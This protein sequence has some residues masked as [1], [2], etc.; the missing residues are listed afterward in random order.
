[1]A[2]TRPLF[3]PIVT[4]RNSNC[5][6]MNHPE[7]NKIEYY[8]D[9]GVVERYES[10]RFG[11]AGGRHAG[12]REID[13]IILRMAGLPLHSCILDLPIGTG[14]LSSALLDA[15]FHHVIGSDASESMLEVARRATGGRVPCTR[16]DAFSTGFA[17]E[18]FDVVVSLRF[19]FHY[20]N[21][22][23]LLAESR[24][25]LKPGG[26]LIFDTLR[27]SPRS[28]VDRLQR[29][30]GGSV[31]PRSDP[32]TTEELEAEG[33]VVAHRDRLL[34]LPSLAYRFLPGFILGGVDSIEASTP[35]GL[36]SKSIWTARKRA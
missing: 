13:A 15:G 19:F 14:R 4:I 30:L 7:Q 5:H 12:Q 24:R 26:L 9:S 31:Y 28:S 1:M 11:S 29:K 3:S 10:W 6:K 32:T 20:R 22:K 25:I 36:R 2:I 27:W 23:A 17:A 21:T 35:S 16:G 34:L 8:S 33:F 18:T